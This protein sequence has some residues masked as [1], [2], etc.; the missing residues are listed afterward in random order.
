LKYLK[1]SLFLTT[2]FFLSSNEVFAW[3]RT[4]HNLVAEIAFQKL[5]KKTQQNVIKFLDGLTIE[6]ASNWMDNQRSDN[7]FDYLKP[8][9][10]IN[11]AKAENY[12][13]TSSN[14]IVSE[15]NK[16]IADF[17]KINTLTDENIKTDLYILFHLIGDLHQPLHCGYGDDK[18][19][20]TYQV[21]F[22]GTGS[23][24]HKVWDSEIIEFKKISLADCL[25]QNISDNSNAINIVEWLNESK[26]LVE[27]LYPSNHKINDDYINDNTPIIEKQLHLA[28]NHL[29]AVLGHYFKEFNK[30][31]K[32]IKQEVKINTVKIDELDKHIGETVKVCTK[33]FGTKQLSSGGKPTFLN[34]GGAY[35]NSPL[36]I[37]IW[38][39]NLKNFKNNPEKFYDGKN[40]CVTGK[41]ILYKEKPEIIISKE[42]EIEVQ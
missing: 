9:H 31:P 29:A 36:T 42:E 26:F 18:G 20:N 24:L 14:N 5:D 2:V 39:D 10:Y 8:L 15:L 12:N 1:I 40:I 35:P 21:Q 30:E 22:N 16:I 7:A 37:L 32:F 33:I 4:G 38:G 3:G 23:N 28:G 19:G 34:A 41:L 17:D 11:I 13:P 25:S 27:G 6:E